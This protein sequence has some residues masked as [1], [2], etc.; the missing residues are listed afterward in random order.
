[1]RLNTMSNMLLALGVAMLG[2][3]GLMQFAGYGTDPLV[4]AAAAFLIGCTAVL[5]RVGTREIS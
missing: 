2:I 1:M 5:D 3:F 4:P